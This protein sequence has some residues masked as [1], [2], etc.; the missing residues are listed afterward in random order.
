MGYVVS[1]RSAGHPL[2]LGGRRWRNQLGA[3]RMY[4]EPGEAEPHR[5]EIAARRTRCSP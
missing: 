1:I 3:V 4:P 2:P 5:S